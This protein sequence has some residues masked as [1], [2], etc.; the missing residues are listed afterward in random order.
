MS[1][2]LAVVLA[3]SDPDPET[4]QRSVITAAARVSDWRGF[5]P[6]CARHG[7]VPRAAMALRQAGVSIPPDYQNELDA[8][9]R[10]E[11]EHSLRLM[12]LLFELL[13]VLDRQGVVGI[14]FKGPVLSELLYG[15]V[16]RRSS[17]DLDILVP[18]SMARAARVALE[19]HGLRFWLQMR[20]DEERRFLRYANEY[21][22]RADDGTI[23][24]LQWRFAPRSFPIS[25]PVQPMY[26]RLSHVDVSGRSVPC[27]HDEDLLLSLI[28][29]GSKHAWERI[30]WIAD[31][32]RFLDVHT[33]LEWESILRRA[34]GAGASRMLVVALRLAADL[35]AGVPAAA[36]SLI[37]SDEKAT[38]IVEAIRRR[39]ERPARTRAIDPL[40]LQL[41]DRPGD[42]VRSVS[43]L[44]FT[45]TVEDW[46][47]VRLPPALAW[48][49][50]LV[51][52]FRLAEKYL[53]RR[54]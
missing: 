4:A 22:L 38:Q 29:H 14:P 17:V 53:L 52:P 50:P 26:S 36:A 19:R 23:V 49:Y 1:D 51:R 8:R 9:V 46:G 43:S 25:L 10:S 13:E 48:A 11:A 54:P 44:A 3:C 34:H 33:S 24:E 7:L 27:L 39:F 40:V 2:L 47:F 45:P 12:L 6:L 5:V 32:A 30:G 16:A 21:G 41:C 31:I 18:P 35:G 28:V 42:Q 20:A 37:G 15:D